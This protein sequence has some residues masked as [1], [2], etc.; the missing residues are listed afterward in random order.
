[1]DA[2]A[3]G[4]H[5]STLLLAF[6]FRHMPDLIRRGH[7]Y[8]AQPPLYRIDVGKERHWARDDAHKAQIEIL[9]G[10]QAPTRSRWSRA[11]RGWAR[12]TRRSSARRRWTRATASC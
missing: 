4:M 1:M 10:L 12:W 9:A 6:F 5:I 11:S 3:D 8:L 2:D 7:V